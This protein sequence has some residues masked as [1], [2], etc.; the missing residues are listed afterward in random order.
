MVGGYLKLKSSP[1]P[2]NG[3]KKPSKKHRPKCFELSHRAWACLGFF[4]TDFAVSGENT[5]FPGF[6]SREDDLHIA[7]R[8]K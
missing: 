8:Y 5:Q 3:E 4:C 6:R 2:K 7:A 1:P